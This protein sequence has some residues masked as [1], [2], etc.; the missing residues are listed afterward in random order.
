MNSAVTHFFSTSRLLRATNAY[1][2]TLIP[3][4]QSPDLFADFHPIS[5]LN[6]SYKIQS[7]LQ[8]LA[9]RLSVILPLRISRHQS[10]FSKRQRSIQHHVA[11]AHDLFQKLN[12]KINGVSVC[13]K[14]DITKAFDKLQWNFHFR[15]L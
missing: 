12:S 11:L 15:A 1:F 2:F 7:H 8:D 4:R 3:K 13:L 9:T 10:A 6:F 14:L 5:L